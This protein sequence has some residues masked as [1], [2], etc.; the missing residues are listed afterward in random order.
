MKKILYLGLN[1]PAEQQGNHY[2]HYPVIDVVPISTDEPSIQEAIHD[3]PHYTH[4]IFTS[5]NAVNFFLKLCDVKNVFGKE[6]IAVGKATAAKLQESGLSANYIALKEQ[7]EGV[8]EI[9]ETLN[10]KNAYLFW[11]RSSRARSV[12]TDYLIEKDVAYRDVA[13][14]DTVCQKPLAIPSIEDFDEIIFTSPSTVDGFIAI[15]G[16]LPKTKILKTIGPIT[17]QRLDQYQCIDL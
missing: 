13:I 1:L 12:I 8:I 16:S 10:L 4:L 7:A 3:I 2:I 15:F 9:L 5:K 11:P 6:I 17:L 14:Y